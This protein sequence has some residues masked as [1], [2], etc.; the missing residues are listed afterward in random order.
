MRGDSRNLQDI[1]KAVIGQDIIVNIIAPKLG[2]K[3]NYDISLIATQNIVS[4]MQKHG[5]KRYFGQCGAWATDQLSDA[6][7]VMQLGFMLFGP[8]KNIYK[9]KKLEDKAVQSGQ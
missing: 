4:A 2:D 3:I 7:L 8:L 6:S 5:I 1:E 9:Y